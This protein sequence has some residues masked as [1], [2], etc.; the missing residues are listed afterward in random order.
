MPFDELARYPGM[1]LPAPI[2]LSVQELLVL[3]AELLVYYLHRLRTYAPP[4]KLKV[5]L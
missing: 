5:M 1:Q 4:L 3:A 2:V